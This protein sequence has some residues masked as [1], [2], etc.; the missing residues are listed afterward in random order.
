LWQGAGG[1]EETGATVY[2]TN[3]V[4]KMD[5]G[6]SAVDA[7]AAAVAVALTAEPNKDRVGSIHLFSLPDLQF[8]TQFSEPTQEVTTMKFSPEGNL[9]VAAS[10]DGVLYV[11][12]AVE[13]QWSH[14]GVLGA[15]TVEV[16]SFATKLDFSADGLYVRCFFPNSGIFRVFDVASPSFGRDIADPTSVPPPPKKAAPAEGEEEAPPAEEAGPSGPP[17]EVLRALT[18]AS[19]SCAHNWDTKGALSH[20]LPGATDRFNHLLLTATGSGAVAV[21]RVPQPKYAAKKAQLDASKLVTFTAHLGGVSALAFIEEGA[22]LVT[23]GAQDGTLRVWKVNYDMDE[24]EPDP[25]RP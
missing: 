24:F 10:R 12:Q 1:T 25:V 4:L 7:S 6:C 13:G 5:S 21:E 11:Y 18:W 8:I 3:K 15:N 23:A 17:L 14:K 22:R 16:G 20:L 19:N 9:L 2:K